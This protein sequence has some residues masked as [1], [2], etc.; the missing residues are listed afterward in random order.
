MQ[1]ISAA[2]PGID[3]AHHHIY[4]RRVVDILLQDKNLL[5]P[6]AIFIKNYHSKDQPNFKSSLDAL[7]QL[8]SRPDQN[9]IVTVP[10]HISTLIQLL[11]ELY[12]QRDRGK[13][14]YQ[15]GAILELLV[16]HLIQHRYNMSGEQC[17]TN[18]R[19]IE[20]YRDITVQEV[21]VAALSQ[22]RKKAE[23]Y[24]CKVNP[25]SF[26]PYDSI[27]L[28]DLRNAASERN[29]RINVGFVTFENDRVMKIKVTK[30]H[31]SEHIKLYGLD[32][33]ESLQNIPSMDN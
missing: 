3:A 20:N 31:L 9:G 17:L 11:S 5:R 18:Q 30:L 7:Y 6:T 19:F 13:I 25:T 28:M 27:N 8:Y 10:P 33:L 26:E 21:D 12:Q 32:S 4:V 2:S 29:Y 22:I 24:E 23:G 16:H 1:L 15:R 14:Q